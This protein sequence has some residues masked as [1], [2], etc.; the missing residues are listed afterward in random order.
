MYSTS[1]LVIRVLYYLLTGGPQDSHG[2]VREAGDAREAADAVRT[3]ARVAAADGAGSAEG[4][5]GH[6][7]C[8]RR[9]LRGRAQV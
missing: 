5:G 2:S 9:R 4:G 6:E 7:A 8:Q 1:I 3:A